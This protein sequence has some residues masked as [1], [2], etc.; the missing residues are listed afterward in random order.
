MRAGTPRD[1]GSRVDFVVFLKGGD[2]GLFFRFS[3]RAAAAPLGIRWRGGESTIPRCHCR[4]ASSSIV[5]VIVVSSD[6]GGIVPAWRRGKGTPEACRQCLLPSLHPFLHP[7]S[8]SD[9]IRFRAPA[10]PIRIAKPI[11][12]QEVLRF[13]AFRQ[14]AFFFALRHR[15]RARIQDVKSNIMEYCACGP[16]GPDSYCK[17][18]KFSGGSPVCGVFCNLQ[19]FCVATPA[20]SSNPT[21]KNELDGRIARV[22]PRGPNSS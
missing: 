13:V 14:V 7:P 1:P 18:N 3:C 2:Y 19:F 5:V 15:L 11:L 8:F 16:R 17:T 21:R 12:F 9:H 4:G 10:G 6:A 22:A 20:Q